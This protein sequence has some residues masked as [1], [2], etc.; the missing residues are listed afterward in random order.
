MAEPVLVLVTGS[1]RSGTSSLAGS[2]ARLGLHV[3]GP[4]VEARDMNPKGLY[5]TSWVVKFHADLL[6]AAMV[7][8]SD[9]S[10]R[11]LERVAATV[12]GSSAPA[13]LAHWLGE[14]PEPRLAVKDNQA[15]WF[16]DTWYA[17]AGGCGRELR[18]LTA[19]RH[20]A[21]VVGSRDLVWGE[22]REDQER[23]SRE[24]TNVA[25]WL[26][27]ALVTELEG[28]G[29]QRAFI[30]YVDLLDGWR[31]ALGR[32]SRQLDLALPVPAEGVA[33]E[34]DEWLDPGLRRSQLTWDDL[35]VPTTLRD[36]AEDAWQSMLALVADPSDVAATSRLDDVRAAYTGLYDES[37]ALARDESRHLQKAAARRSADKLRGRVRELRAR[38]DRQ[39]E[40]QQQPADGVLGR[41]A[42][43]VRP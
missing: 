43:R 27:G 20:P 39:Q 8:S 17:V 6:R 41:L 34:L 1:G 42:R 11:A 19:L 25:A 5:E 37:F 21:E 38:L 10:P 28:R 18:L 32:V 24:T 23:R 4:M 7:R 29:R 22:G 33:H 30:P 16:L 35:A 36:L 3:P 14:Q 40:Q 13:E 12:A 9:G 2:L 26:N 15:C 31:T